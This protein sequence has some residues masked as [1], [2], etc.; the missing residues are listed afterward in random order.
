MYV[1][2]SEKSRKALKKDYKRGRE[3]EVRENDMERARRLG[4]NLPFVT[5]NSPFLPSSQA[6]FASIDATIS[7]PCARP[8]STKT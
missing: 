1:E 4:F 3:C 5:Y 8:F 6:L 2:S 7:A